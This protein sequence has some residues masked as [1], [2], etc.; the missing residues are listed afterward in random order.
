P[1]GELV[2]ADGLAEIHLV[3]ADGPRTAFA[4]RTFWIVLHG[5]ACWLVGRRI[6]LRLVD[7]R[8]AEPVG[9]ADYRSFFGAPVR[10]AQPMSRIAFDAHHLALP[11]DRSEKALKQFLRAA[12]ANLLVRYRYDAGL[13]AAIRARLRAAP[14]TRWPD[15]E[16]MARSLRLSP[17]TLR[18]RLKQEGRS[19]NGIRDEIRRDLA[20]AALTTGTRGVAEIAGDLGFAEPSAFHRAFRKWTG[21]SP[22]A[23]RRETAAD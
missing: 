13:V 6:P 5:I 10:F 4:Y 20:V 23:F 12:P 21:K 15:A 7:F 9:V 3:D 1:R 8:C 17:S 19:W 22:G 2:V 18:H 14:P 11:V 16:A